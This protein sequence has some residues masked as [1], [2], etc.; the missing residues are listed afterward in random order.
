MKRQTGRQTR[1]GQNQGKAVRRGKLM[2]NCRRNIKQNW[3][4]R[5]GQSQWER[6]E[7]GAD[8]GCVPP[9]SP[10]VTHGTISGFQ[11]TPAFPYSVLSDTFSVTKLKTEISRLS[12]TQS[13]S[14][15]ELDDAEDLSK[16]REALAGAETSKK[17]L[18]DRIED[19]TRQLGAARSWNLGSS[20]APL[21]SAHLEERWGW[22]KNQR[23]KLL[24][25]ML[26][27]M[28]GLSTSPM[29]VPQPPLPGSVEPRADARLTPRALHSEPYPIMLALQVCYASANGESNPSRSNGHSP[30]S[31]TYATMPNA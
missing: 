26:M 31:K 27:M 5:A 21:F 13:T 16:T 10:G 24:E 22:L 19:L 4:T 18:E 8:R 14:S 17:D 30:T 3:Q 11:Q 25:S 1:A 2:E 6:V 7:S 15:T 29:D 28:D 9:A 12:T 20:D 23:R